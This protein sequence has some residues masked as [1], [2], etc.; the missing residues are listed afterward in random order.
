MEVGAGGIIGI[1]QTMVVIII[2][3]IITSDTVIIQ[4]QQMVELPVLEVILPITPIIIELVVWLIW[5]ILVLPMIVAGPTQVSK[6]SHEFGV[7]QVHIGLRTHLV[8]TQ[9]QNPT[10]LL[11]VDIMSMELFNVTDLVNNS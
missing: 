11:D 6:N 7:L 8:Q 3:T 4:P 5:E 9:I 2:P 1:P 10:V